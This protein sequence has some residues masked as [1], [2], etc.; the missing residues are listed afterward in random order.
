ME[1]VGSNTHFTQK[2]GVTETGSSIMKETGDLIDSSSKFT[3]TYKVSRIMSERTKTGRL[4][5]VEQV[6]SPN[7]DTD[8][9]PHFSMKST[10]VPD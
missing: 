8:P 6:L 5:L 1:T 2:D 4:T 7:E 10:S 3:R 9:I